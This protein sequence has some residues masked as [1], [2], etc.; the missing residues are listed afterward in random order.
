MYFKL[1]L[2]ADFCFDIAIVEVFQKTYFKLS[3]NQY[4]EINLYFIKKYST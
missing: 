3:F 1:E 4:Y 2:K